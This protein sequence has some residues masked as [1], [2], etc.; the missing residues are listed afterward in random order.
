MVIHIRIFIQC[1]VSIRSSYYF[2]VS[3]DK[4]FPY[5]EIIVSYKIFCVVRRFYFLYHDIVVSY[6]DFKVSYKGGMTG[7][8]TL[9]RQKTF[10]V[11][12]VRI[13]VPLRYDNLNSYRWLLLTHRPH[14][15]T[16]HSH[17]SHIIANKYTMSSPS[18]PSC[19][20]RASPT[21]LSSL[22]HTHT[23]HSNH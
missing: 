6:D 13:Q 18:P 22:P 3:Y 1:A 10:V 15:Y 20:L 7:C 2:V 9:V 12:L 21:L 5:D 8:T 11:P 19:F 14:S 23:M 4:K 16:S 17:T